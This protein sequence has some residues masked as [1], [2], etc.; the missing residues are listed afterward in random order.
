MPT[1]EYKQDQFVVIS[2]EY[3]RHMLD[4]AD[5]LFRVFGMI[6]TGAEEMTLIQ[7]LDTMCNYRVPSY[8]IEPI[9]DKSMSRIPEGLL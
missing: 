2:Q 8:F 4:Q 3:K 7:S 9:Y 6:R 1:S 5:S